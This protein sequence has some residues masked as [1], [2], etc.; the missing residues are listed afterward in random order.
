MLPRW[1]H[2]YALV[3][4]VENESIRWLTLRTGPGEIDL[5]HGQR[6]EKESFRETAS[7][8]V[9]WQLSLNRDSDFL[10]STMATLNMEYEGVLPGSC[11]PQ[12]IAVAFF[13]V[14]V[15]RS[16]VLKRL[17]SDPRCLWLSSAELCRGVAP[18][19]EVLSP[20]ALQL[21]N[22]FEIVQAWQE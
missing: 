19:G 5:I 9:A 10:I 14:D 1:F 21:I 11:Q 2:G 17:D 15:Y 7:R 3:R 13:P 8:E 20:I 18:G 22:R 6:L 4:K 16:E 12:H